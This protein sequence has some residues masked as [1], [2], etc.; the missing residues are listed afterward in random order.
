M[1]S[2]TGSDVAHIVDFAIRR[3]CSKL[4]I[5]EFGVVSH[6]DLLAKIY[7]ANPSVHTLL[8]DF[9]TTYQKWFEFGVQCQEKHTT[10]NLTPAEYR[11]LGDLMQH[12]EETRK[13]LTDYLN[14]IR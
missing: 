12:R 5:D 8:T 7:A 13:A 6:D 2:M 4:H 10:G 9:V 3:T 14:R 1:I 11:T